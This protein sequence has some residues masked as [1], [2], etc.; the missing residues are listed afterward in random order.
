VKT[1]TSRRHPSNL[2]AHRIVIT[3]PRYAPWLI[4]LALFLGIA[5]EAITF[6]TVVMTIATVMSVACVLMSRY[7]VKLLRDEVSGIIRG[8]EDDTDDVFSD[9]PA[10]PAERPGQRIRLAK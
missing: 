9:E 3:M 8:I 7:Q 1:R 2:F 10:E 6:S 4:A 5:K